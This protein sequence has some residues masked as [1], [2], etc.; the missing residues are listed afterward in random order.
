MSCRS[1]ERRPLCRRHLL[2]WAVAVSLLVH[3]VAY[4]LV[5][6]PPRTLPAAPRRAQLSFTVQTRPAP[7][8]APEVAPRPA[9]PPPRPVSPPRPRA[10]AAP[11]PEPAPELAS[12]PAIAQ[13]SQPLN[14]VTLAGRGSGA[15]FAM[16]LSDGAALEPTRTPPA[17][18]SVR[19]LARAAPRSSSLVPLSDL[20]VRPTPPQLAGALE[21][22]YPADAR[23]RGLSGIAKV[24]ARIDA[25]GVVRSVTLLTE[26]QAAFGAACSQ[27][28]KGSRWAPPKDKAGRAVATEIRYTCRFV[29]E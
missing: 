22:N 28:L 5:S 4:A 27:T 12:A 3:G 11:Q 13:E 26:S 6:P 20:S 1:A 18:S 2:T 24:R 14:G 19:G 23:R 25:D 21:R 29:V 17:A 7:P 9:A 8:R 15:S 10:V 16:P